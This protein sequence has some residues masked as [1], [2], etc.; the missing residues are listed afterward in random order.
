MSII[1]RWFCLLLVV[2]AA[3]VFSAPAAA[4]VIF[5]S[6]IQTNTGGIAVGG[7][8]KSGLIY[9]AKYYEYGD[10]VKKIE[11]RRGTEVLATNSFSVKF[12]TYANV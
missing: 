8:H 6:I 7:K 2:A 11:L 4:Y 10:S 9:S 12:R 1:F 3:S 5:P